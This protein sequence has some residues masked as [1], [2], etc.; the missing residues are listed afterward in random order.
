MF[1]KKKKMYKEYT[2][3]LFD[4]HVRLIDELLTKKVSLIQIV[5]KVKVQK[6]AKVFI[7]TK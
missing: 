1:F 4:V 7:F 5:E 2:I 6:I 3:T